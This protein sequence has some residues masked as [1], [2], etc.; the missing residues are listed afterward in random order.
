MDKSKNEES[1]ITSLKGRTKEKCMK[2]ITSGKK[3]EVKSTKVQ[4]HPTML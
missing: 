4:T 2:A 3:E 1:M